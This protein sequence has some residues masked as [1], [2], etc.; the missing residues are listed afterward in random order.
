[1]FAEPESSAL[2]VDPPARLLPILYRISRLASTASAEEGLAAILDELI[3]HFGASSGSIALLSPDSGRLEIE[4]S[5]GLPEPSRQLRLPPGQ[6]ITGWVALHR[7]ALLAPD[8]RLD[9]RYVPARAEVRCEMAAPMEAQ[10]Q[11]IGVINLDSDTPG[12]FH[13]SHLHD[14]CLLTA[15]GS[16]VVQRVWEAQHFQRKAMQLESLLQVGQR[17]VGNLNSDELIRAV[18]Q[19]VNRI[20]SFR[21][22]TIHLLEPGGE[23]LRLQASCPEELAPA[24]GLPCRL[25]ETLSASAI[26]TRKQIEIAEISEPEVAE[27][28]DFP[29]GAGLV[30][31]LSTP[32]VF[33]KEVI[34][35]INA[36][37]DRPHR[38]ADDERRLLAAMA[39]LAAV[40]IQ[41]ARLYSRVF[42]S[43]ASLRQNEKLTTLGTL[44]AE[45]A[46]EI[47][48]PLTVLKLL[49]GSL[50]LEFPPQD[51]R[52]KDAEIIGEKLDQLEAIVGRVLS[53]A[54][55][56]V[57]LHAPWQLD[58]LIGDTCL[59]VRLKLEQAKISLH[60]EPSAESLVVEASKGQLQQVLLN[61]L[62]NA[63]A[64]MPEGGRIE[65]RWRPESLGAAQTAVIEVADTGRGIPENALGQLFTSFLSGRP[66]G[67]GLGLSIAKR[68]MASHRGDLEVAETGPQGTVMRLHLPLAAAPARGQQG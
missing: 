61:L 30:A 22:C 28:A 21:L 55:A 17:L 37:T 40:A 39:S 16:R 26:H 48:N 34:G 19:E 3:P 20:A 27:L 50:E 56:P 23:A 67:T 33:E 58:Q 42:Q 59:L 63:M 45:I 5:R 52:H 49:F 54:K 47:R 6:G 1:M 32:I 10:G 14:L 8:V 18:A 43:E 57:T 13:E 7:K 35:V 12:A 11:V 64:A 44:A 46:H 4:I 62:L 24:P 66:D 15:E 51:P 60:L 29:R 25:E 53:F 65:V 36:F 31:V 2:T 38:F 9:P 41:N 68:I